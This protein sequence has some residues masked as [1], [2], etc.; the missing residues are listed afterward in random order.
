VCWTNG[1]GANRQLLSISV[2]PVRLALD[3]NLEKE[4]HMQYLLFIHDEEGVLFGLSEQEQAALLRE[5]GTFT[6]ELRESGSLVAANR[7]RPT[8]TASTVRIREGETVVTDGPFAETKEQLGGYYLVDVESLDEALEWAAKIPSARL[9]S[10]EVR[11]LFAPVSTADGATGDAPQ[12]LLLFYSDEQGWA[13]RSEDER[14][15]IVA[16]YMSLSDELRERGDYIAG[17]PLKPIATATT[18]RVRDGE[19]VMTDGPFAET[20]EQLGGFFLIEATSPEEACA[21]AAKVPAARY[22]SVEVRP[23]WPVAAEVPA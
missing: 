5:Y 1:Q 21:V 6:S 9:G 12:Y 15:A 7:L 10:I 2:D 13:D 3:I 16:E 4:A 19:S 23:I 17:A 8:S 22:G 11:P 20:K 18:V 14:K